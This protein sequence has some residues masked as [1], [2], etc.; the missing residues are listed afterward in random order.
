MPPRKATLVRE[1][2]QD[3]QHLVNALFIVLTYQPRPEDNQDQPAPL[4]A[5]A[6]GTPRPG[7]LNERDVSPT[8]TKGESHGA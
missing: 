1:Y 5:A 7:A 8:Q 3:R 4:P 2:H 6:P